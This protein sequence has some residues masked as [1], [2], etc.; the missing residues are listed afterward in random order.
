[1]RRRHK[2]NPLLM[3]II[4]ISILIEVLE[5]MP[6]YGNIQLNSRWKV[7]ETGTRG[8]VADAAVRQTA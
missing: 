5:K 8:E 1:M 6:F 7:V 3:R 2:K 4:G